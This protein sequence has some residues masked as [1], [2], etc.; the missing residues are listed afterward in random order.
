[1]IND[2]INRSV[3]RMVRDGESTE[4]I[5]EVLQRLAALARE[6]E[7]KAKALPRE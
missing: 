2:I 7:V 3:I 6:I 4:S 1:M 5:V